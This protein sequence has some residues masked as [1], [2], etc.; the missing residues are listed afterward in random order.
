MSFFRQ[1]F[2]ARS[3]VIKLP[4]KHHQRLDGVIMKLMRDTLSFLLLCPG[5]LLKIKTEVFVHLFLFGDIPG[6]VLKS[7]RLAFIHDYT[8]RQLDIR[9][10]AIIAEDALLIRLLYR[11]VIEQF[12]PDLLG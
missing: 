8:G 6:D 2:T 9:F 1:S 10:S 12:F 4:R 11:L 5:S 7:R 3:K